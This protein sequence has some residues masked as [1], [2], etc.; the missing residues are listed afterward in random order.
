M[1]KGNEKEFD[2]GAIGNDPWVFENILHVLAVN[3]LNLIRETGDNFDF[4]DDAEDHFCEDVEEN[5]I[6]IFFWSRSDD[7]LDL[8]EE[9]RDQSYQEYLSDDCHEKDEQDRNCI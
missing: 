3:I 7:E 5:K 2:D 8:F 6:I 9:N 1:L 4:E